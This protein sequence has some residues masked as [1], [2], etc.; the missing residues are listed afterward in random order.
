MIMIKNLIKCFGDVKALDVVNFECKLDEIIVIVGSSGCGKTTL[1]RLIAGLETPDEGE[2]QI[3]DMIVST[4][5]HCI[6][7]RKREVAL[8]FQ[9]LALWPH[10]TV[11]EHIKFVLPS[12][13]LTKEDIQ[14]ATESI[15]SDVNLR[16]YGNRYPHELSGGEQQRLAIA[17]AIASKPKYLLL[18][19]PFSSLDSILK[20]NLLML[21]LKLK[22]EKFIGLLCVTHNID[23]ANGLADRLAVMQ[24]G[25]IIQFGSKEYIMNNPKNEFVS[26]L[27]KL[28]R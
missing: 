17:R 11:K 6:E 26:R 18:D 24:G 23:E 13:G 15:L 19:E 8:V 2:I 22:K 21:M 1:L 3:E 16:G 4:S 14:P 7:P 20:E 27:L 10:M 28:I 25:R 5:R 12:H 9:D